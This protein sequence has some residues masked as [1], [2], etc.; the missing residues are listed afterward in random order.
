MH[1]H[2]GIWIAAAT[3]AFCFISSSGWAQQIGDQNSSSLES[4]TR[5]LHFDPLLVA[6]IVIALTLAI[7][8]GLDALRGRF[9][10][11][12]DSETPTSN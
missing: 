11:S 1:H 5:F 2:R 12:E 6:A 3:A 10:R 4:L 8:L 9:R 7:G